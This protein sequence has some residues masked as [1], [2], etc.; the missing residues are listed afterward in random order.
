MPT[1]STPRIMTFDRKLFFSIG[2]LFLVFVG[3]VLIFESRLEKEYRQQN[4]NKLLQSY[5]AWIYGQ[6]QQYGIEQIDID[7]IINSIT[8]EYLRVTIISAQTGKVLLESHNR[9]EEHFT[10]NHFDRPEIQ[11]AVNGKE[12]YAIRY[13]NSLNEQYFYSAKRFGDYIVRSS[14]PFAPGE[15]SILN[16]DSQF[17]YFM[18]GISLLAIMLLYYFCRSLGRSVAALNLLSQRAEQG[19][20]VSDLPLTSGFN[21]IGNITQNLT[22]IYSRLLRTKKKLSI[23]QEKLFKHLQFSKE[24]LAFFSR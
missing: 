17:L 22:H 15:L 2:T 13:S 18:L 6:V 4:A 16:P 11:Q 9:I 7:S 14:R 21:E 5:N 12:G 1:N 24:G 20:P 19:E 10:S 3:I 8:P 23:E